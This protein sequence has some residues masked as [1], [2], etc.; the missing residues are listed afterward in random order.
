MK[1]YFESFLLG[2]LAAFGSL[3]LELMARDLYYLV[4]SPGSDVET[5]LAFYAL[6]LILLT[7]IIEELFK[8]AVIYKRIS[9]IFS[10]PK[11]LITGSLLVGLGFGL[12]ETLLILGQ[13]G[14]DW[15]QSLMYI[16]EVLML[17][18]LTGTIMGILIAIIGK[19]KK[20]VA[21][22]LLIPVPAVVT[23]HFF[24]NYLALKRSHIPGC[25]LYLY[26][27][28]LALFCLVFAGDWR[29]KLAKMFLRVYNEKT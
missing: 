3:F 28:L 13:L 6:P 18:I 12:V 22:L 5:G 16:L 8:F 20:N 27:A 17:H 14:N 19:S 29:K 11:E 7:A 10:R 21:K 1:K 25:T 15:Q 24:F 9:V 26:L 4:T 23:L 2:I